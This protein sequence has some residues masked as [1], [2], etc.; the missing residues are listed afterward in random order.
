MSIASAAPIAAP[1]VSALVPSTAPRLVFEVLGEPIP[2]GSMKPVNRPG[3][4]Y[5]Q[6]VPDSPLLHPWR[7]RVRYAAMQ[8]QGRHWEMI[9]GPVTL[10]AEFY[11]PKPKSRPKRR[12]TLPT[13]KPDLDK[14]VRA[15]GDA[16]SAAG[17]YAD[18]ARVTDLLPRVRYAEPD[19]ALA[20]PWELPVPGVRIAVWELDA[21]RS[22]DDAPLVPFGA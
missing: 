9:D 6:L 5:T 2:Q 3:Q 8:A 19:P 7:D 22:W 18:D 16:L 11:V 14:L 21:E 1:V 20:L 15:V 10:A 17:T 12:R 4:S 13:T